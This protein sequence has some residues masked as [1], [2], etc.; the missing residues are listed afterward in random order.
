MRFS[1]FIRCVGTSFLCLLFGGARPVARNPVAVIQTVDACTVADRA[2]AASQARHVVDGLAAGGV[3]A[4]LV[5]DKA[6]DNGLA[7]RRLAYFVTMQKPSAGQLAAIGRFRASGGKVAVLQSYSP[8]LAS[9][10]GVVFEGP[11]RKRGKIQVRPFKG[12]WW[13]GNFFSS[14]DSEEEKSRQLLSMVGASVP[15]L[16][17]AV[18]WEA[19]RRARLAADRA[20]G[21]KQVPRPGEIHAVWDHSGEGLYP[22]DWPRTMR[23]LQANRITDLFVNVAGAGFGHYSSKILPASSTLTTTGDQLSACLAA[24]RGTGI[25]VHAWI[26]CFNATRTSPGKKAAFAKKGW[27][28]KDTQGRVTEYLNPANPDLRWYLLRTIDEIAR[29]Y[30]VS[31]IHLDFVRWYEK[32]DGKP[33]NPD[34]TISTFV[35][36]V[37]QRVRA[38]RPKAILSAAVLGNYPSCIAS[39][40]QNWKAW[41][42][43]G[44]VDYVVPM[45]YV[46]DTP[47]LAA[48]VQKQALTPAQARHVIGGIG[49][50]ANE[51]MLSPRQVVDQ[52]NFVRRA[53]FAGVALF[54]LDTTLVTKVL[55]ILRL[56]LFR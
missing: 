4:E 30:A 18:A 41:I 20:Y 6:L 48:L 25:R 17:N 35:M 46:P 42:D 38:I 37:R 1:L 15:G 27:L 12:G 7:G 49:V 52:I 43:A 32:A 29:N 31:G 13:L 39:V 24:A 11:S 10:L 8:D 3:K 45:N 34:R 47:R 23:V 22:G 36:A 51:S 44:L 40:G 33:K 16:W 19:K 54:D 9:S 2:Y 56:G 55:P 26:L 5:V 53:G 14:D 50:T 21:A 28:L